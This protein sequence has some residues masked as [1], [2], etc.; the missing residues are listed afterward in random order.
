M[1]KI[2]I[3]FIIIFTVFLYNPIFTSATTKAKVY[4]QSTKTIIE[5]N[6]EIE[7]SFNINGEKTSAYNI[8][9]FFDDTKFEFV[10]G[11]E[12]INVDGNRIILVWYDE[13][14]GNGAKDGELGKIKFKAKENGLANFVIN[15]EF[16]TN[17]G[18]LIQTEFQELQ[19]QVGKEESSI[20]KQDVK[21]IGINTQSNNANLK[22]LI[23]NKEG[24]VPSFK[25][26]VYEYDLIVDNT[27]NDLEIMTVAENSNSQIE[28]AGNKR[29]KNRFK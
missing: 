17:K 2:I 7:I 28:I 3:S 21:E 8:E 19:I 11:E 14:G 18:Q 25:S 20:E 4:L 23:L 10:S 22:N 15:G 24:L 1:K 29:F 26:D 16:Y 12:N 27:V 6:E 9:I 5:K 13:Q